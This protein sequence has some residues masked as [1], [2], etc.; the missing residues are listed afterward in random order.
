[1]LLTSSNLDRRLVYTTGI[2]ILFILSALL[3]T[4]FDGITDRLIQLFAVGAFGAFTMSQA[5]MVVHWRKLQGRHAKASLLLILNGFGACA[6]AV[7]LVI[8]IMAK[9]QEGAWMTAGSR[10]CDRYA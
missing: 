5:G 8:I 4:I 3:L 2:V 9:F 7:A 10:L 6:T 1:M